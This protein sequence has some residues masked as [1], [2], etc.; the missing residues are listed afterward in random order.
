[1]VFLQGLPWTKDDIVEGLFACEPTKLVRGYREEG[2]REGAEAAVERQ[3]P[4]QQV[5]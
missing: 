1:M 2:S 4:R 3:W 5:S